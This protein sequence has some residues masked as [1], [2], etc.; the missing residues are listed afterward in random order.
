MLIVLPTEYVT[1]PKITPNLLSPYKETIH[2][3]P[4]G[5]NLGSERCE[6]WFRKVR[7]PEGSR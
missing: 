5:A 1:G 4:K 7:T 2:R 3:V 6:F